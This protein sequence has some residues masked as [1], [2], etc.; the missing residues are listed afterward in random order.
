MAGR[1]NQRRKETCF[2]QGVFIVRV[3]G[4]ETDA[5]WMR[6]AAEQESEDS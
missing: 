6:R 3:G 5:E 2:G 4:R 1:F